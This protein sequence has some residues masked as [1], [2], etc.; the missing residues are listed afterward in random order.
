MSSAD[1]PADDT[2][3]DD[4]PT[5]LFAEPGLRWRAV[6]YGPVLCA[7]ILI[8]ELVTGSTAHWFALIFCGALIAGFVALQVVAGRRHVSVELTDTTLRQGTETLPLSTVLEVVPPE[9]DEKSWDAATDWEST[10]ALGE[11]V[12]VPRR[13]TGIG[14]RLADDSLVQA[15][16]RDHQGLRAALTT[17]LG[18]ETAAVDGDGAPNGD[19]KSVAGAEKAR[20]GA[21]A[22][23]GRDSVSENGDAAGSGVVFAGDGTEERGEDKGDR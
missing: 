11:L 3:V 9:G 12:G 4:Q 8:L 20:S 10:R 15:W 21:E 2:A 6:A 19:A 22:A 18:G 7:S 5:I 1:N 17:A 23:D 13:R 16:A 14:L